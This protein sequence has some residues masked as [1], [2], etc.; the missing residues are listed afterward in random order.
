V[1]GDYPDK[2]ILGY[3]K[4]DESYLATWLPRSEMPEEIW[5]VSET[6][7]PLLE[8][9]RY[10]NLVSTEVRVKDDESFFL[11]PCF[12]FPSPAGEEQ[13]EWYENFP[14]IVWHGANGELVQPEMLGKFAGEAIISY[15]GDRE[16]WKSIEV[17]DEARQWVKLYACA[18]HQ[19]AYHF[20]PAQAPECIGCAVAIADD[21]ED[22][23][24]KLKEI[25]EAM[26]SAAVTLHIEAMADLIKEIATAE[27]KGIHFTHKEMPEPAAVLEDS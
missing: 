3:E 9:E 10:C 14:D 7:K 21:P 5:R 2:I 11:D 17:P 16:G 8:R 12:R 4:K 27:E 26:A 1:A 13:L 19:N 18:Y 15:H 22:V 20:K 25:Q 23:I 24:T 6:L